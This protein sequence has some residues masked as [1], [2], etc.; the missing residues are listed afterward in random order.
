MKKGLGIMKGSFVLSLLC[1]S[2]FF[3]L[4]FQQ[5]SQGEF[6]DAETGSVDWMFC[7]RTYLIK[8]SCIFMQVFVV[9]VTVRFFGRIFG[10]LGSGCKK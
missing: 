9:F 3:W 1:A 8:V 4:E 10:M 2:F 7:M 6:Y 5:N